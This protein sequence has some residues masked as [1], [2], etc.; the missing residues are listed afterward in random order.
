[1]TDTTTTKT[2]TI[3]LTDRP[4][5]TI[6]EDAWPVIATA[7]WWDNTYES[8]ANRTASVRVREHEDGRRIVY[9][10]SDSQWQGESGA[11]AGVLIR[12]SAGYRAGAL[13]VGAL[14]GKPDTA[15]TIRAIHDVTD[16]IG[17]PALAAD[18][19]ADLPAEEI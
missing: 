3:T 1:M 8:Q 13:R 19:I 16:M 4:P 5:V 10:V 9:G 6:R 14:D 17:Y 12:A 7:K 15:A 18:C 2:R 11:K